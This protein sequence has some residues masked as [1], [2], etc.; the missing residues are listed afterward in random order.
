MTSGAL[1]KADLMGVER[2]GEFESLKRGREGEGGS[3]SPKGTKGNSA[4]PTCSVL[5]T[6]FPRAGAKC[7]SGSLCC[8]EGLTLYAALPGTE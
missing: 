1:F 3:S 6:H 8:S 2:E 5:A 7:L 4:A